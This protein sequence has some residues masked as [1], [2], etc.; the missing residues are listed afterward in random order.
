MPITL[1]L[2]DGTGKV[3]ANAYASVAEADAFHETN[4]HTDETWAA[5]TADEKAQAL[6]TATRILDQQWQWAGYKKTVQQA[7]QWPRVRVPDPDSAGTVVPPSYGY[8]VYLP[9]DEVPAPIKR[10]TMDFAGFI[11]Q[12]N[13][14]TPAQGEGLNSFTLDGVMSVDF[15]HATRP[16]MIPEWIQSELSKYGVMI[17]GKSGTVKLI[18]S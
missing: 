13:P 5:L 18:R 11:V 17:G 6:I 7:L 15:D 14:E 12:T 9:D 3:D 8:P 1:V 10:A 2:E 16:D 4:V